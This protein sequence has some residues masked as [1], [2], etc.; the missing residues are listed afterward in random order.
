MR[1]RGQ[2]DAT[3]L[4]NTNTGRRQRSG[5]RREPGSNGMLETTRAPENNVI[6]EARM[7][8][9]IQRDPGAWMALGTNGMSKAK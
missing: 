5:V 2:D 4:E 6:S 3:N 8:P 9:V 7:V 1:A